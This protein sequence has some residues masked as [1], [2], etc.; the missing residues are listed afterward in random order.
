MRTELALSAQYF[1]MESVTLEVTDQLA[2]KI[3]LV[4]MTAAV[5]EAVEPASIRQL[6]LY[7]IAEFIIAMVKT[8]RGTVF[9]KQMAERV[10]GKTKAL[11][12]ARRILERDGAELAQWVVLVFGAAVI[13]DFCD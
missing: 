13:C 6:G 8:A 12:N 4:Q 10:V 7:Q 1:T 9:L 5:V 3:D 11:F 2:V